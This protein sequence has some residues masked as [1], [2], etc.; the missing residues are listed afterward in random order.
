MSTVE[1]ITKK[2]VK[3]SDVI[4]SQDPK[5][6]IVTYSLGS[7]LGLTAYD[8]TT[9][10]GGLLHCMLPASKKNKEKAKVSPAMFV[11]TGV[12]L[13]LQ[14]LI[15]L[16]A[17][18]SNLEIRI[19]GCASSLQQ[20]GNIKIGE[21]NHTVARKILWK[22]DL[23]IAGEDVGGTQP[24]TMILELGTGKTLIQS[25]GETREI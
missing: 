20:V 15:E 25:C 5:E 17:K 16:G 23:M 11:D 3:I 24:R 21:R 9:Q 14:Q 18:K 8:P 7:C 13:L 12:V 19:A 2:I 1:A 22:N 6:V 10:M 4:V